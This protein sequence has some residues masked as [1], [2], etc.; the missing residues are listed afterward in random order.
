MPF[1]RR[2]FLAACAVATAE[3]N[4]GTDGKTKMPMRTLGKT[5]QKVTLAAFG[6]G[7]RFLSYTQEDEALAALEK[8]LNLG[9]RYLDTAYGYGNGK[10]ETRVGKILPKWRKDVFV[11][12]KLTARTYDDA[13]RMAEGCLKRLNTDHVDLL[14]IHSL[15]DADDL[16]KVEAPDGILKALYKMREQ[17]MTRFIGVT[18]HTDPQVL[19]TAIGRN[20]FDCTQMA[21]NAARIGML[22]GPKGMIPNPAHGAR[23]IS[24]EAIALPVANKKKMGVIAMKVFGQEALSTKA[25]IDQLIRYSLS[26]PV[27]A[28]VLGMPKLEY[29][30]ENLTHVKAFAPMPTS[31]MMKFSDRLSTSYKAS[32]DQFF[33]GHVDG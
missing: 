13:M 28:C 17:K 20:D 12:T 1:S 11:A 16:A 30:D 27:S 31:E 33:A 6:C 3:L 25:P 22:N 2:Q 32:L 26:L 15:T 21:L 23:E 4:A 10:S 8:A 18:S 19:A 7:S 14:H 24:F 9:I 5:G 29:I